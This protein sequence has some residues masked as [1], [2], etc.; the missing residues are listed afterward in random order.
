MSEQSSQENINESS[1]TATVE[2]VAA[3]GKGV[4]RV[5]GKVYFV[6]DTVPGDIAQIRIVKDNGRYADA[7]VD[8]LLTPSPL[9]GESPCPWSAT[10]GGCQWM[11]IDYQTQLQWKKHFIES[12][13]RRIGRLEEKVFDFEVRGS[14]Q[15]LGFR[16]RIL[17]RARLHPDG[18]TEV[19]YFKR[20]S[21]DL[22]PISRCAVA[23]NGVNA[24]ITWFLAQSCK[25]QEEI[26]FR[27]EIQELPLDFSKVLVSVYPS[28]PGQPETDDL[29]RLLQGAPMVHWAGPVKDF[30]AAPSVLFDT[31]T[32][33]QPHKWQTRAGMFQ[34]VNVEHNHLLRKLVFDASMEINPRRVL[35]VFCGSGNLSLALCRHGVWVEGV[36]YDPRAIAVARENVV[37]QHGAEVASNTLWL[38]TDAVKHLW[39]CARAGEKFDLVIVDPPR[40]GM[41]EGIIPLSKIGPQRIIYVSCD[42]GTMARDV[43]SLCRKG[44]QITRLTGLDF[45]PNTWHVETVV[46]LDRANRSN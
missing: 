23:G 4:A 11:G 29:V 2:S 12:A 6:A 14:P 31:Q 43:G 35:D 40:E 3:G 15:Q 32:I 30:P 5:Q 1:I 33:G 34:Q 13:L 25:V 18:R 10:C 21:R 9:R 39:K 17:L 36:E 19:G 8:S 20:A 38:A 27:M 28:E 7:V 41:Y 37:A 44:W 46:V 26:R 16:N 42:P 24:F 45:F 22:V